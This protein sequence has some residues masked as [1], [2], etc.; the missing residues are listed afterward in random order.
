MSRGKIRVENSRPSSKM[1]SKPFYQFRGTIYHQV[2]IEKFKAFH[3]EI[4]SLDAC[5]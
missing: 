4:S 2:K 1:L 5:V 3:G